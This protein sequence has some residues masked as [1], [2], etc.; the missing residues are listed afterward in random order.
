MD[1]GSL[2]SFS[3]AKCSQI[4]YNNGNLGNNANPASPKL[5]PVPPSY[6]PHFLHLRPAGL[7]FLVTEQWGII[8]WH[9]D[10]DGMGRFV[11]CRFA[12][13]KPHLRQAVAVALPLSYPSLLHS[14][15]SPLTF[16]NAKQNK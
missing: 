15:P 9:R 12:M 14:D 7:F 5:L 6:I 4:S 8:P 13:L 2:F 11:F 1:M 10:A 3:R 16:Q